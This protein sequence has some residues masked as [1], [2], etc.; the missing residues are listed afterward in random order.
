LEHALEFGRE[1]VGGRMQGDIAR[2]TIADIES[3]LGNFIGTK[4]VA[5]QRKGSGEK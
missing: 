3:G 4:P 2:R 5:W 1:F